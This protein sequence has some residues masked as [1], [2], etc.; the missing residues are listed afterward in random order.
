MQTQFSHPLLLIPHQEI[1]NNPPV[2]AF[3][4]RPFSGFLGDPD[5]LLHNISS[6]SFHLFCST[7][8]I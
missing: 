8:I 2:L 3:H 6:P 1:W 4:S 7:Y 5:V